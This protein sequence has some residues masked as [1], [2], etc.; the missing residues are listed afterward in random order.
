MSEI[1]L[2]IKREFLERV[3]TKSF[4][5]GTFLVPLFFVG[6]YSIPFLVGSE[7]A[8]RTIVVVD[9][10]P[11]GVAETMIAHLTRPREAKNADTYQVEHLTGGFEEHREALTARVLNKE[12]DGFVVLPADILESSQATYR[13][14]NVAN[15]NVMQ[16]IEVATSRAVQAERL[17]RA[18]LDGAEV[19]ALVRN[20]SISTARITER[21]EE[22][23]G[24]LSVLITAYVISLLLYFLVFFYGASV[25]RSVLEEKTNRIAEVIVSSMRST[26][27]MIG[28]IVGVGSVALLQVG[29]W[30]A[31][32]L[33][34]VTQSARIASLIGV[35]PEVLAAFEFDAT[36]LLPLVGFFLLGFFLYSALFAALGA[37]ISTEQEGQ[38]LQ[39]I[40]MLPLIVPVMLIVPITGEPLGQLAT[41]LSLVPL[42]AP[43]VM[44]MRMATTGI[45]LAQV[46]GSLAILLA[47]VA[48]VSWLAAKIYRVGI[49]STGK[50]PSLAELGRWLRMA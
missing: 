22:G 4:L 24:M 32:V 33:V 10:A 9:E 27:L 17:N 14:R 28:K 29:I 7:S 50:K 35:S 8:E 47:S 15:I 2:V 34:L 46:F 11:A 1:Y 25:M 31:F 19:A 26:H 30:A 5:I 49:L 12:I 37:A 18:G 6:I 36:V 42:T 39:M 44:P 20:V 3:R 16:H 43:I 13:A 48:I 23:G 40:L 21:G 41:T 45:P 38:S